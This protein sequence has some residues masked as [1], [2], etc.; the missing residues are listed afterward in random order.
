MCVR[1]IKFVSNHDG[2][3]A[4]F[5]AL[6]GA[7]QLLGSVETRFASQIYS[8]KR[9]IKDNIF[10]KELFSGAALRQ[11]LTDRGIPDQ[12]AEYTALDDE[13]ISNYEACERIKTF[14]DVELPVRTLLRVS[15]GHQLNLRDICYGFEEAKSEGLAAVA[16]AEARFPEKYAQ[17]GVR[18][19]AAFEKR[20]KYVVTPLCLA[21]CTV[22]PK[23]VQTLV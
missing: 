6:P 17:L 20:V 4:I 22:L 19:T 8:S 14:V 1:L 15:D 12:R 23:H 11:Y 13:F 2:I 21:A 18:V 16:A 7:L 3:F 5:Q 9:I 10:L